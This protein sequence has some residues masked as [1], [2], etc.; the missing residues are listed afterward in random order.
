MIDVA[1]T[2]SP[3]IAMAKVTIATR[4]SN[5]VKPSL[6]RIFIASPCGARGHEQ[7]AAWMLTRPTALTQTHFWA[8]PLLKVMV[9]EAAAVPRG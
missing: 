6:A 3:R 4:T 7:D 8:L 9:A 2:A 5:T 1:P